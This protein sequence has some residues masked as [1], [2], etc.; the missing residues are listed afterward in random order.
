M[1]NEAEAE[2][3]NGLLTTN[4]SASPFLVVLMDELKLDYILSGGAGNNM[5]MLL[6]GRGTAY[7]QDWAVKDLM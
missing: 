6:E 1:L 3:K 4:T 5:L 7:I 2:K